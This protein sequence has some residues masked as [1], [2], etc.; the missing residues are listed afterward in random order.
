M[1]PSAVTGVSEARG[2]DMNILRHRNL[3]RAEQERIDELV[4]QAVKEEVVRVEA[5]F[6]SDIDAMIL[7]VLH[8]H[9]GWGPKRLRQFWDV[10]I[11]EHKALRD[12]YNMH[13]PGDN[14]YLAKRKLLEIGVDVAA[15]EEEDR[16]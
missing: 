15:W 5:E 7:Y 9:Y 10:F 8:A 12:H 3:T 13:E 6:R 2:Y 1:K 14:A 4:D 16:V 11:E